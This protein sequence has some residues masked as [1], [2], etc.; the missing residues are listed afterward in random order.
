MTA[1]ERPRSVIIGVDTHKHV[2][3][4]VAIDSLGVRLADRAFPADSGGYRQLAEWAEQLGRIDALGIE[5]TGSYG[6]GLASALRR[7]GHRIVEV[8]RGNRQARR[9]NGKSD[10]ADA[11][12]AAR[13]VL[14]GVA[15][16]IPKAADGQVEMIRHIKVA[17][18]TA[19]KA[20]TTAMI[21]LKQVVVNTPSRAARGP[22]RARRQGTDQP[23]RRLPGGQ[24]H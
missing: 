18:D 17:R 24:A 12:M 9:A 5:G 22:Q 19:V 1:D 13:Q 20:R 7:R 6:A 14:A 23:L 21:T 11:E 15:K 4:A 16:A 3:V 10:T 8:N 2:H